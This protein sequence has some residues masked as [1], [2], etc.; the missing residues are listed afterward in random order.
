MALT[1]TELAWLAGLLEGEGCFSYHCSPTI[2]I[3][4]TDRDVVE[5]VAHLFD[6]EVTGPYKYKGNKK[7]VYYAKLFGGPAADMM[8]LVRPYMGERRAGKID[9]ILTKYTLAP[10]KGHKLGKG[11][12]SECHPNSRHYSHGLCRACYKQKRRKEGHKD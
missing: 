1:E 11:R 6:K 2:Q 8:R 10:G 7:P 5:C 3:G 12:Q 4:M 9:E